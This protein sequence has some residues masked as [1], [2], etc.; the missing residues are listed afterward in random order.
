VRGR[1]RPTRRNC[2]STPCVARGSHRCAHWP[3]SNVRNREQY[4]LSE[5]R[6]SALSHCSTY[7]ARG[8]C[9]PFFLLLWFQTCSVFQH[10]FVSSSRATTHR[11]TLQSLRLPRH[12]REHDLSAH[13]APVTAWDK[14]FAV[15]WCD[16][17]HVLV[18]TKSGRVAQVLAACSLPFGSFH[19]TPGS[20][21]TSL[22][23]S[24][25]LF[26]CRSIS[27][28][29]HGSTYPSRSPRFHATRHRYFPWVLPTQPPRPPRQHQH[30]PRASTLSPF[31][32]MAHDGPRRT[33][34]RATCGCGTLPPLP[35]L[36]RHHTPPLQHVWTCPLELLVREQD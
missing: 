23:L 4:P 6:L 9:S 35:L 24:P 5:L 7:S 27:C 3:L 20:S 17:D 16:D 18:G 14:V 26:R 10:A 22:G 8:F 29:D 13:L 28:R 15:A 1:G 19:S 30:L 11:A 25:L 12:L 34:T 31:A 33:R 21:L 36:P 32:L 2:A